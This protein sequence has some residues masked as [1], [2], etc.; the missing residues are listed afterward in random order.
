MKPNPTCYDSHCKKRQ[1]QINSGEKSKVLEK[2]KELEIEEEIGLI[3]ILMV[4]FYKFNKNTKI[5]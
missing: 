4:Y 2:E 5:K 3:S 1:N